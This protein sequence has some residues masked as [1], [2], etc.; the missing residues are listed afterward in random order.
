MNFVHGL[1]YKALYTNNLEA[2]LNFKNFSSIY[3]KI[4]KIK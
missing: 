4:N 2:K 1:D 3:M